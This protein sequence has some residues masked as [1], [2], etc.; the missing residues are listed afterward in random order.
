MR[1]LAP[2]LDFWQN[3][4]SNGKL[5]CSDHHPVPIAQLME[6][7]VTSHETVKRVI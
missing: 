3:L 7:E 2:V 5:T 1:R 6:Q 4:R